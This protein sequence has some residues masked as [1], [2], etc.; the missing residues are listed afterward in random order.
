LIP[1]ASKPACRVPEQ[2]DDG[3]Q[4]TSLEKAGIDESKVREAIS[5]I[6]DDTYKN[7]H[8]VLIVRDGK[9]VFEEY[10]DGYTWDYNGDRYRGELVDFGVDTTQNPASVTKSFTSPDRVHPGET[11]DQRTW[12]RM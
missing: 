11:Y 3:W 4:T 5:R 8:S 1:C 7:I 6:S 12:C 9:L 2:A 10:F